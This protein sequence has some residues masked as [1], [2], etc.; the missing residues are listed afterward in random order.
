MLCIKGWKVI[1]QVVLIRNCN[2]DIET[3]GHAI[4]RNMTS[5]GSPL[6]MTPSSPKKKKDMI[7]WDKCI[8]CQSLTTEPCICMRSIGKSSLIR[9]LEARKDAVYWSILQE[10]SPIESLKSSDYR[11]VYH[12]NCYK[13][14]TS[15][16]NCSVYETD[17][18]VSERSPLIEPRSMTTRSQ[19]QNIKWN[20]CFFCQQKSFKR[21]FKVHKLASDERVKNLMQSALNQNDDRLIQIIS[22]E[23][24]MQNG[25]YHNGCI[26]KYMLKPMPRYEQEVD[27]D[28]PSHD[29]AFESFI[30]EIHKDLIVNKKVFT[31]TQLLVKYKPYLPDSV[32]NSYHS[33]KLQEKLVKH[34][35]KSIVIHNQ[36]GQGMSNL[37][38]S[39]ELTLGDAIA[40][41]GRYKSKFRVSELEN[42]MSVE[43]EGMNDDQILH[44]AVGILRRE[45]QDLVIPVDEY[46]AANEVS[47]ASSM[48]YLPQSLVKVLCW[49]FDAKA[50]SSAQE[51]HFISTDKFR[52]ALGIA[53]SIV[54][55]SKQSFTPFHLGLAAQVYHDFGSRHLIDT[56]H[57]HG[58]CASYDEIRLFTTSIANHEIS[59][60]ENDVYIPDG[61]VPLVDGGL[62][63]Q[64]GADNI[65]LNT[66][67]LDGK[68]S[69][70]SLA[71]A[72]FQTSA[73]SIETSL[74]QLKVKRGEARSLEIT[75]TASKLSK[76]LPFQ[77]P[78]VKGVPGRVEDAPRKIFECASKVT[79][80]KEFLWVLLRS[81][82]RGL[83]IPVSV[84]LP[85]DQH[86]PFWTGYNS[87]LSAHKPEYTLVS[88]APIIDAKPSDMATIYTSMKKCSDMTTALGQVHSVQTY[89]QQLYAVA[90]QVQFAKPETFHNHILRLGG[91]HTLACYIASVGK[92]W[93][94]GGLSDL[95]ID[96]STYAAATADQM[97]AGKQ[98]NRGVRGLMLAYEALS[99]L[100]LL[101]FFR[102]CEENE[103][104]NAV[105]DE[106]W[107]TVSDLTSSFERNTEVQEKVCDL[108]CMVER[109]LLPLLNDFRHWGCQESKTF[110]YWDMFL[111]SVEILLCNI[112]SERDGNWDTHLQSVSAMLPYLFI[113]NRVNY[114]RWLP[115]YILDMFN[116]PTAIRD[117]FESGQFAIR[118]KPSA[119][120]GIWADMAVEK[121]VI[122]DSKGVGGIV[123][124]TRQKPSLLRWSLTMH[125]LGDFRSEMRTRSGMSSAD[126]DSHDEV[127]KA[128]MKRDDEHVRRLIDH[129]R[130]HMTDPFDV[131]DHP[132]VLIN[133]STG[134][135]A[136]KE[137]E[138]ALLGAV[139]TGKTMANTFID[140]T[141]NKGQDG[142]FY[143]PITR[144]KLKTFEDMTKTTN[145]KCR[146]GE[147][148]TVNINP[149]VIFRRALILA[150]IREDVTVDKVLS[151]PIGPIPVAL[152]HEDGTMRKTCKSD[153]L[154]QLESEVSKN[155]IYDQLEPFE[156]SSTVLIRDGMALLQSVNIKTFRTFGEFVLGY[157]KTQLSCFTRAGCVVDIFDRYDVEQSIKSAERDRRC[158]AAK[159]T[160]RTIHLIESRLI[161]DWKKF[162]GVTANKQALLRFIGEFILCHHDEVYETL[163]VDDEL[164]VAGVFS[165]PIFVKKITSSGISE[166]Q[167]LYSSHEEADTRMILHA[168]YADQT[169]GEKNIRG[170]IIIQ[171]PDTDVLV[172]AVHFF[173]TF[174]HTDELWFQTGGIT[175]SK[176]CRRF[177]PVHEIVTS[178]RP[179]FCK[180]LPAVHAL[181]G[182]DTTCSIF[183]IGKKTVYKVLKVNL[184]EFDGLVCVGGD[185]STI[186][187][188][189]IACRKFV[190]RLYDQRKKLSSDHTNLNKLRARLATQKDAS[191]SKLPPSE[192]TFLQH[193]L[194][195]CLQTY[196]WRSSQKAQPP[197]KSPLDFGWEQNGGLVPV[198][199]RGQMSSDFLQDLVCSCK[200]KSICSASCVCFE[201]NL[202]CTDLC[203]CYGSDLCKNVITHQHQTDILDDDTDDD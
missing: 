147:L 164:Y 111:T 91:F 57:A 47:L 90:K 153:L 17:E 118:Q 168:T 117:A 200:G 48:E 12:K 77:K 126:D 177:I 41:A 196:I 86:I 135:H 2:F 156:R 123:G 42:A 39:A 143:S 103:L 182:C 141:L 99:S 188:S 6:K 13:K 85:K 55:I 184:E 110:Q 5:L 16:Q 128:A 36:R 22:S 149:E 68:D 40:A 195:V 142:N 30:A 97:L 14:Y 45:I 83:L 10:V 34:Y 9:A 191:L 161:P 38:F 175:S 140:S 60:I 101:S 31:M 116:L 98:F 67:T 63:V 158:R 122:K 121:T 189:L 137:V 150:N 131:S 138:T 95:L 58:F 129:V 23:G 78:K 32:S 160:A 144:S 114:S 88:Y 198:L 125:V 187:D 192:A 170:R 53:D 108:V 70:H 87:T 33:M 151:Y 29:Q 28:L 174:K 18:C 62:L 61:I 96:S 71:R 176:D 15:R 56:L 199:F 127:K 107:T 154:H 3:D 92:L 46:P 120:N 115:V 183:G 94:S 76:C 74:R 180:I 193:V 186:D 152:F 44:S 133:I 173:P 119:F 124:I 7:D 69:F 21:D 37:V 185:S 163:S 136:S 132:D 50:F 79:N 102:W 106:F 194:R 201:Q 93:G 80:D 54:S 148:K 113:T 73:S 157:M 166:C 75:D 109:H 145:L 72:V 171:S 100:R 52:K 89:D 20:L 146:S 26:T 35:G 4:F 155:I 169:F 43:V 51:P 82:S 162:L 64:E 65:D 8:I 66:E 165:D 112:R 172:L 104:L 105:P 178:L 25:L 24:F 19:S 202:A 130:E 11:V 159:T 197:V 59:K 190:A 1:V 49:L 203:P 84:P 134:V 139:Q 179:M 181:T 167:A 81:V 27:T